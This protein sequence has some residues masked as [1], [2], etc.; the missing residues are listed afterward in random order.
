MH[1]VYI[2]T[3]IGSHMAKKINKLTSLKIKQLKAPGWYPDGLGLYLQVSPSGSK[4]WVYRYKSSTKERRFGLGAYPTISLLMARESADKCRKL[5]AKGIDPIEYKKQQER[6]KQLERA[7]SISFKECATRYIESHKSGWKN[8]KHQS[9]WTN[10][11]ENYA[12]PIMGHL[13]VQDIS[14][15]HVMQVLEPI[16]YTKTETA[17]RIRSRIENIL[18]WAKVKTYRTGENPALWRGHLDKLLPKQ[19]KVQKVKHHPALPYTEQ[20]NFYKL[21]RN[22]NTIAAKALTFI[23]LTVSRTNEALEAKWDEFNFDT[24]IWTIP[25]ERMKSGTEHRVPLANETINL[26]DELKKYSREDNYLFPG[27]QEGRFISDTT[28]RKGNVYKDYNFV[29]HGFRST[30][31]DW[32]AE[33][34]NFPERL[35][36]AALAHKIQNATQ[37]AY[38]RGDKIEK[39]RKLMEAW[40]NYCVSIK[41]KN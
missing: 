28:I 26:L 22:K 17:S 1:K 6:Q 15:N 30:F 9:Q 25:K 39:R 4:S 12:H 5:R 23:I 20:P 18:D 32:C 14:T 37:A 29:T 38:E 2:E 16:W 24:A 40:A 21:L 10:T 8:K 41:P 19:S 11:L 36:E 31:R 35:A 13:P 33:T 27:Q 34:T 7:K 3:Y